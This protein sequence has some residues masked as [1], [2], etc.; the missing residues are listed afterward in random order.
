MRAI[1]VRQPYAW[2]IVHAGKDVENRSRNIAGAY[3]GPVAIHAG[4]GFDK[5]TLA[6]EAHR[7]AHGGE[8][9]TEL[10]FGAFIGVVDLVDVHPPRDFGED[11]GC[12][13]PWGERPHRKHVDGV[14]IEV[15]PAH[16]VLR[17][18]RPLVRPIPCRGQLGL[19][20]P[21]PDTLDELREAL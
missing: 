5:G 9:P 3:R 10:A 21:P 7:R 17:D 8:V 2:A 11:G 18:P 15:V 16:L 14:G 20:T 6:G 4:L 1:T 12:C 13:D 19:W